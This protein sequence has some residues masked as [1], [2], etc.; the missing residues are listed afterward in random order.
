MPGGSEGPPV[1]SLRCRQ[2]SAHHQQLLDRPRQWGSKLSMIAFKED[3]SETGCS[4]CVTLVSRNLSSC[5]P[6]A[7]LLSHQACICQL[8]TKFILSLNSMDKGCCTTS[9]AVISG[10]FPQ[11]VH[12]QVIQLKELATMTEI[13]KYE[14]AVCVPCRSL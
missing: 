6:V 11:P 8:N 10:L 1:P 7:S 4:E 5:E 2:V 3:L 14:M 9:K 12:G 13:C